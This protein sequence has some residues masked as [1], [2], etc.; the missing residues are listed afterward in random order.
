MD[1]QKGA[2]L[3]L[4]RIPKRLQNKDRGG[5]EWLEELEIKNDEGE[6]KKNDRGEK[7][8]HM[9][10]H[11][12][13]YDERKYILE[14]ELGRQRWDQEFNNPNHQNSIDERGVQELLKRRLAALLRP[15]HMSSTGQG[16]EPLFTV[17]E[18]TCQCPENCGCRGEN[19]CPTTRANGKNVL[20]RVH[21]KVGQRA[22]NTWKTPG[23]VREY[24]S[25]L[26]RALSDGTMKAM[27][28]ERELGRCVS[29]ARKKIRKYRGSC[30]DDVADEW[31]LVLEQTLEKVD[32]A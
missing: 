1:E 16:R 15:S 12:K 28:E 2:E 5:P 29:Q 10:Y 31:Q 19:G 4:V 27:N 23:D 26:L 14:D 21:Q 3:L 17:F 32:A 7:I 9:S 18:R 11:H 30:E 6:P 25:R 20:L 22:T 24:V 8:Y 13:Y